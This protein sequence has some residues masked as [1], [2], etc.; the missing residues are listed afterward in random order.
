MKKIP[1]FALAGKLTR[2]Y[3][4]PPNN[5]AMRLDAPG[6]NLLYAAGGLTIWD[7]SVALISKINDAY[8]QEWLRDLKKRKMNVNGV[9]ADEDDRSDLREFIAYGENGERSAS[10]VVSHFARRQTTFPKALLGYQAPSDAIK[11]LGEINPLSPAARFVPKE[12]RAIK[13]LHI[14]PF[15]FTSQSQ[16]VNLFK[17]GA[18]GMISLD[19]AASYMKP[20]FWRDLRIVLQGVGA[21]LP[22]EEELRALFW[23]E[24][25]D[26]WEMA[27]RICEYGP[28]IVV[29]KRGAQGQLIYDAAANRKYEIPA[30]PIRLVDP[31]G[32]GDVFCGGFLVGYQRTGNP[33]QAALYGNISASL[34]AEGV[35]P[36][37]GLEAMPGLAEARL[38]ALRESAREV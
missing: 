21:F 33:L 5:G 23:G 15:D 34:K 17:S 30:Y 4:L 12:F 6:G 37:A 32:V 24:T 25:D 31:T 26:L 2:E 18:N 27:R 19:P 10:N 3:L 11:N 22:S 1:A 38:D 7:S 28:R 20:N 13:F 29:V 9:Y 8:P 35:G 14:C 36:F 16:I